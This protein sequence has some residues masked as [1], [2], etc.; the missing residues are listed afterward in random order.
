MNKGRLPTPG[1][2]RSPG[3]V[4]YRAWQH[5]TISETPAIVLVESAGKVRFYF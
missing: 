3:P 1:V 2:G 5:L 4:S